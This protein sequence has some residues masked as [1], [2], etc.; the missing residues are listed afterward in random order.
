MKTR[1]G[2]TGHTEN[3]VC[4]ACA[5]PSEGPQWWRQFR[6]F[7]MSYRDRLRYLDG[8]KYYDKYLRNHARKP[9]VNAGG[10]G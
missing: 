9:L 5:G 2:C 4:Y 1:W 3:A 8:A 6:D 10:K 7:G